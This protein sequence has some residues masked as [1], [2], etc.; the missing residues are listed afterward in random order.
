MELYKIKLSKKFDI[1]HYMQYKKFLK[2]SKFINDMIKKYFTGFFLLIM[3]NSF[4]QVTCDTNAIIT[5][6]NNEL[7]RYDI[8]FSCPYILDKTSVPYDTSKSYFKTDSIY[9][10]YFC[11][12]Q[13]NWNE[14]KIKSKYVTVEN[15]SNKNNEC[16][17]FISTP[18]FNTEMTKCRLITSTHYSEWGGSTFIKYYEKRKKKWKLIKR[19]LIAT[20]S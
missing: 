9:N 19:T 2:I 13:I 6:I 1:K 18:I 10:T 16:S 11:G 4:S 15:D 3:L 7:K 20:Y 14:F 12:Y 17:V 8:Y 5:I